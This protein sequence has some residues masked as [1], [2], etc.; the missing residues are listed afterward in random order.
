[1]NSLPYFQK[2]QDSTK[3]ETILSVAV[4]TLLIQL[5]LNIYKVQKLKKKLKSI[6]NKAS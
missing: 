3:I 4:V 5:I 1:M 2:I 6:E